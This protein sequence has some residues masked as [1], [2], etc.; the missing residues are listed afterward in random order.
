MTAPTEK[1][2]ICAHSLSRL[3]D[4]VPERPESW[5]KRIEALFAINGISKDATKF[6]YIVSLASASL[7]EFIEAVL[8]NDK[9]EKEQ[10]RYQTFKDSVIQ[11]FGTT[12]MSKLIK[13]LKSTVIVDKKPSQVMIELKNMAAG[14]LT[15]NDIAEIFI[16]R[17]PKEGVRSV[18][19]A[20][21]TKELD[22]LA[23]IAD[24][25]DETIQPS[26][27]PTLAQVSNPSTDL[28]AQ[29]NEIK[30]QISE[31]RNLPRKRSNRSKSRQ[32]H[33]NNNNQRGSNGNSN[34]KGQSSPKNQNWCWYHN[35]FTDNAQKCIQPC[36]WYR[37]NFS[38]AGS[39]T[40]G[41]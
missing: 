4:F 26:A 17:M 19:I 36:S 20:C 27:A 21:G 24:Q 3:P 15:D 33:N 5:F 23:H 10:T 30:Q 8:S 12:E 7:N 28:M 34:S 16:H 32:R 22:K 1:T 35:K 39:S 9:Y 18:L 6:N 2:A 14:K 38:G 41:N 31:L 13:L 37:E 29:I 40:S 25:V 11:S